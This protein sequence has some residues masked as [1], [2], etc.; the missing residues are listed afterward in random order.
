MQGQPVVHAPRS[1]IVAAFAL[2]PRRRS[3]WANASPM[4]LLWVSALLPVQAAAQPVLTIDDVSVSEGDAG[5]TSVFFDVRLDEPAPAGGVAFEFSTADG[6]ADSAD[7]DGRFLD[8]GR[9]DEGSRLTRI[10]IV[11]FGDYAIEPDETFFVTLLN[12][13][14]AT[15]GDGQSMGTILDDDSVP[16]RISIDDAVAAEGD[17]LH[18]AIMLDKPARPG[19]VSFD[20]ATSDGTA[21]G[22][23][24]YPAL[25]TTRITIPQ[26][27]R[28]AD[29]FVASLTDSLAEGEESFRLDIANVTGAEPGA[30]AASGTITDTAVIRPIIDIEDTRIVEGD[31]GVTPMAFRVALSEP[32]AQTVSVDYR[33][34]ADGDVGEF[35]GRV[36]FRPGETIKFATV[37]VAGDTRVESDLVIDVELFD[38]VNADLGDSHATG[39]VYNDDTDLALSPTSH[40]RRPRYRTLVSASVTIK[41]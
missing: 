30:A 7:Y 36:I 39:T 22:G 18:F 19:G 23:V 33:S 35:T 28:Q 21:T 29:V 5:L 12:S 15:I 10:E 40:S 17:A 4:L 38:A 14:G 24:D 11:V 25:P 2:A 26:G 20:V 34:S 41:H 13:V 8:R 6:S 37:P 1:R 3:F 32:A 31:T 9:I 27:E 16:R